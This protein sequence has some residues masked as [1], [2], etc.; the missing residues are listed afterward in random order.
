MNE[1]EGRSTEQVSMGGD[2]AVDVRRVSTLDLCSRI[3]QSLEV[4]EPAKHNSCLFSLAGQDASSQA[5]MIRGFETTLA[6]ANQLQ[7]EASAFGD[8]QDSNDMINRHEM[9]GTSPDDDRR[10]N[11]PLNAMHLQSVNVRPASKEWTPNRKSVREARDA[12]LVSKYSLSPAANTQPG[13]FAEARKECELPESNAADEAVPDMAL[14]PQVWATQQVVSSNSAE[15]LA[16]SPRTS[17]HPGAITDSHME[18]IDIT[19]GESRRQT[20]ERVLRSRARLLQRIPE[21]PG[22]SGDGHQLPLE[23]RIKFD[24]TE[25]SA[26]GRFSVDSRSRLN[27]SACSTPR[28]LQDLE[29][30]PKEQALGRLLASR[31]RVLNFEQQS[32]SLREMVANDHNSPDLQNA[33]AP[34]TSASLPSQPV[35]PGSDKVGIACHLSSLVEFLCAEYRTLVKEL[36]RPEG[37]FNKIGRGRSLKDK[38]YSWSPGKYK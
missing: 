20:I 36:E 19:A 4:E 28:L 26:H 10:E 34:R 11:P 24:T 7:V 3:E 6:R 22:A 35:Q 13:H 38:S 1:A 5:E 16:R 14:S 12:C 27:T 33:A 37:I 9:P 18:L 15:K 17:E 29:N 21:E 30:E 2:D 23:E 32:A 31:P 8:G 25:V